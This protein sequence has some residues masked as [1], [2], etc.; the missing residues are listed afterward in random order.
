MAYMS[1]FVVGPLA[2]RL[3]MQ[4]LHPEALFAAVALPFLAILPFALRRR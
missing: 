2:G 4:H 3:A 1:G